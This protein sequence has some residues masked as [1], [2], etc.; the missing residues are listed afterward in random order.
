M[1]VRLDKALYGC[2]EASNLWYNDLRDK[3][4]AN[5]FKSNPYD[6][7]VFYKIG[8][9]DIQTT[10]VVHV[11]DLFVISVSGDDISDLCTYLKSVYPETK[12]TRGD[13]VDYI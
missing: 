4:T 10:T 3:L 5:G 9:I 12:E 1:V 7:C 6:S 13:V 11:H 2:V 8:K